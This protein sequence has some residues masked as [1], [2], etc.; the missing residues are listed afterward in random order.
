VQTQARPEWIL[1]GTQLQRPEG[2]TGQKGHSVWMPIFST[3]C[4]FRAR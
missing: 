4:L 3:C 1:T 2:V